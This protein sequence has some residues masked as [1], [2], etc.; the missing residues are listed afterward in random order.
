M[1]CAVI[2][3]EAKDDN[4]RMRYALFHTAIGHCAVAWHDAGLVGVWLPEASAE[5]LRERVLRRRP[6][7]IESA[8]QGPAQRAV[9]GITALLEGAHDDLLDIALDDCAAPE[10]HRRVWAAARHILPG[11]TRS[12]LA[13]ALELQEPHAA[14]AVGQALGRNPFPIVVPCH[15]VLAA[16]GHSGGFS[17]PGGVRTKLRLLEIEGAFAPGPDRLL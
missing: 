3:G 2:P 16:G 6:E 12:Y 10:F 11:H 13:L 14:R 8:P 7:A 17:A 9:Q 1:T 4:R 5:A 15:R